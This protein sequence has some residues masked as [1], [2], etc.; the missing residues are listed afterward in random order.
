MDP[1]QFDSGFLAICNMDSN[2]FA[3]LRET[4]L[5]DPGAVNGNS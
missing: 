1:S 2:Y 4:Q 5:V 3:S